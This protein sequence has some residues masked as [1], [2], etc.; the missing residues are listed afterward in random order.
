MRKLFP[1]PPQI[2]GRSWTMNV[3]KTPTT[4][5]TPYPGIAGTGL[6]PRL[7]QLVTEVNQLCEE[8]PVKQRDKLCKNPYLPAV[9]PGETGSSHPQGER[10]ISRN[11]QRNPRS[12]KSSSECRS[13][14]DTAPTK[15]ISSAPAY[16]PAGELQPLV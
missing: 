1:T 8:C 13:T 11:D 12:D 14:L 4:P 16:V 2:S 3:R 10:E 5:R 9:H 7:L 6:H 15:G